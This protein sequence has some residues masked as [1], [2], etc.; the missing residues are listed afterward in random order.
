MVLYVLL[1]WLC[2][3]GT[4]LITEMAVLA[5]MSRTPSSFFE[6]FVTPP[7]APLSPS[8]NEVSTQPLYWTLAGFLV[9]LALGLCLGYFIDY[10]WR[11]VHALYLKLQK[12][13]PRWYA[14]WPAD[15]RERRL[16][17]LL[18]IAM[19]L[20]LII[21]AWWRPSVFPYWDWGL[22]VLGLGFALG[23]NI[24]AVMHYRRMI[25]EDRPEKPPQAVI[26]KL[27]PKYSM[28]RALFIGQLYLRLFLPVFALFA[29]LIVPLAFQLI[30]LTPLQLGA[31]LLALFGGAAAAWW[32]HQES[33]FDVEHFR[34]DFLRLSGLGL[35]SVALLVFGLA[36]GNIVQI[37][38]LGSFAS[39]LAALY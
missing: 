20:P 5:L 34:H 21:F 19:I 25:L 14:S 32:A 37:L 7:P 17:F 11:I 6:V 15:Q 9:V 16:A 4:V 12:H 1:V 35:V 29:M 18:G 30:V 28:K 33:H 23:F 36:S 38:L 39:Y 8:L 3:I 27:N 24:Q 10:R 13:Y 31:L 2:V 26:H 22:A